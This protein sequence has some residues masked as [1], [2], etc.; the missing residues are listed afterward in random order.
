MMRAAHTGAGVTDRLRKNPT[1][2]HAYRQDLTCVRQDF[3]NGP[4]LQVFLSPFSHN[5]PGWVKTFDEYFQAQT[6]HIISTVVN[7]LLAVR[8]S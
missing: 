5:D 6:V 2:R 8:R 4:P 1:V 7:G 3:T